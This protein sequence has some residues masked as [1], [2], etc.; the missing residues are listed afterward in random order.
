MKR[1]FVILIFLST[2][3]LSQ[4]LTKLELQ[5]ID[6]NN[7]LLR[8]HINND[9]TIILFWATWCL[10]CKKEFPEIQK[11]KDK[12]PEK[13]IRV[14]TISQDSPHSLTK[15]KSF[16]KTHKYDFIYL[17]DPDGVVSLKLLINSVPYTMLVDTTGKVIYPHL[18]YRKGDEIELEKNI[19]KQ[20]NKGKKIKD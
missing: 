3:A 11:L 12:Y 7:F 19:L 14:I 6:G 5:D 17:L 1:L 9:A 20:W 4:D 13:N 2:L 10:P 8:E 18:G 15:V 16:A